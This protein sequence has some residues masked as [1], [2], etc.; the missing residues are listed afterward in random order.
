MYDP[1]IKWI[2][3]SLAPAVPDAD[4]G[5]SPAAKVTSVSVGRGLRAGADPIR[6]A[7]LA[8]LVLLQGCT[9]AYWLRTAGSVDPRLDASQDWYVDWPRFRFTDEDIAQVKAREFELIDWPMMAALHIR[10]HW[11]VSK[12][13]RKLRD[14]F[15]CLLES[16]ERREPA[17]AYRNRW[18]TDSVYGWGAA[19][20][21]TGEMTL[22]MYDS[23]PCG[24][25]TPAGR[26]G[27]R[28]VHRTCERPAPFQP[29]V[30]QRTLCLNPLFGLDVER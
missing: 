29:G 17:F 13:C 15:L 23:S 14:P 6:I 5:H 1:V 25:I 12:D 26:C 22:L 20:S 18:G 4:A 10:S 19:V 24:D 30:R 27:F 7:L 8:I 3:P 21:A 9:H 16:A 28:L 2:A 11:D